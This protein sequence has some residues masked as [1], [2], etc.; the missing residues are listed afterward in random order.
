MQREKLLLSDFR[1]KDF[2]KPLHGNILLQKYFYKQFKMLPK[3]C[4]GTFEGELEKNRID[5]DD[6]EIDYF[7]IIF[8]VL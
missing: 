1:L 2:Q 6:C 5:T 4:A 8:C 3:E 7:T